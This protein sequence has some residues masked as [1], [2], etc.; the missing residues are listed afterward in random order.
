MWSSTRLSGLLLALW[1]GFGLWV[2]F[3]L[4]G[5]PYIPDAHFSDSTIS[6]WGAALFTRESAYA[7]QYPLWRETILGGAPFAANPLNKTA[8]PLQWLVLIFPPTVHLNLMIAL[9][10]ALATYGMWR[11]ARQYSLRPEAAAIAALGYA[12][13]PRVIAHLGAGHLDI[14]YA[15]AWFPLWMVQLGGR[16]DHRWRDSLLLAAIGALACLADM[17][18]FVFIGALGAAYALWNALIDRQAGRL[19][20]QAVAAI[21]FVGMI[22]ALIVPLWGWLPYLSRASLTVADVGQPAVSALGLAGLLLPPHGG[23]YETLVYVG[24]PIFVLAMIGFSTLR[25]R[26]Q[27]FFGGSVIIFALWAMGDNTP[28]WTTLATV[29]PGLTW[30]RVPGR[31]WLVISLI[32]PLLA[33]FGTQAILNA[34]ERWTPNTMPKRVFWW[35]LI[36]A[37]VG[38]TLTVC[39]LT[40]AFTPILALP[41]AVGIALVVNGLGIGAVLLWVLLGRGRSQA[42]ATALIAL[43]F[44]DLTLTGSA[45]LEWRGFEDWLDPYIP[46][47]QR[48]LDESPAR[49]YSPSYALPQAP[50]ELAKL[51]LFYGVDPFQLAGVVRGIEA[52]SGIPIDGYSVVL[53]PLNVEDEGLIAY[54]NPSAVP[55]PTILAQWGVSHLIAANWI[56]VEGVS[57]V[58]TVGGVNIYRNDVFFALNR[59]HHLA[60]AD[61]L[62]P[63]PAAIAHL[64][65]WTLVSVW[66]SGISFVGVG[67]ALAWMSRRRIHP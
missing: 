30:F 32:M 59:E 37:A 42:V 15:M 10:A 16:S 56:G 18:A 55:N 2:G 52:A 13:S 3:R 40:L 14:Y 35:R 20:V 67:S 12:L 61:D 50:A 5:L 1:V 25:R 9:H 44:V 48:L 38:G 7:G 17:R 21:P 54:A 6:H 66:I 49:I 65:R 24:L 22:C 8:Y 47:A 41:P 57:Y 58:D 43:V 33:G 39:G 60:P 31:A 19:A 27:A 23:D 51:R 26:D 63:T 64:N 46:L 45:W 29:I 28:L 36:A 62:L 34:A 53:P 4:D 11:W